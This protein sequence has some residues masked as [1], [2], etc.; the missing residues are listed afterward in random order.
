MLPSCGVHKDS[1]APKETGRWGK[2]RAHSHAPIKKNSKEHCI[3]FFSEQTSILCQH[4]I[5]SEGRFGYLV[6]RATQWCNWTSARHWGCNSISK[7]S[8]KINCASIKI[9]ARL[10]TRNKVNTYVFP[11][12]TSL[13]ALTRLYRFSLAY[14]LL[15]AAAVAW[16]SSTVTPAREGARLISNPDNPQRPTNKL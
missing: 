10:W 2:I 4:D 14:A 5:L 7:F 1:H 16:L 9:S 8:S 3:F 6:P 15:E 12:L 13:N 11:N